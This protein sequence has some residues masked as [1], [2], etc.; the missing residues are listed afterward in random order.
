M[1]N[2]QYIIDLTI[3]HL[4]SGKDDDYLYIDEEDE[5]RSNA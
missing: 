3:D 1:L 5:E 4:L 2:K